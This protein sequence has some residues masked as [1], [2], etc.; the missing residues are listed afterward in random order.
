MNIFL[1]SSIDLVADSIY[2][3][4]THILRN[5]H[6]KVLFIDT[7]AEVEDMEELVEND[8]RALSMAGFR[9]KRFTVTDRPLTEIIDVIKSH[10]VVHINGGNSFYLLQQLQTTG[11]DKAIVE[12]TKKGKIYT[13]SSAGSVI[14]GP[15][16]ELEKFYE[17]VSK[18]PNLTNY[19]GLNLVDF[20]TYPHWG[21]K[22]FKSDFLKPENLNL[23]YADKYKIVL[24]TD[25]QYVWVS[26][27]DCIKFFDVRYDK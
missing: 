15:S 23:F 20:I 16:I 19:S 8:I 1:T 24:L 5:N 27:D 12:A 7:A 22:L 26:H 10:D 11:A 2:S 14:A 17:D 13:G 25:T 9:I 6:P 21:N 18:A 4:I 3:K